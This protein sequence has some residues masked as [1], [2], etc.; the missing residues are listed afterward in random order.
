MTAFGTTHTLLRGLVVGMLVACGPSPGKP[1]SA[2]EMP[3]PKPRVSVTPWPSHAVSMAPNQKSLYEVIVKEFV[4]LGWPTVS[5]F[6]GMGPPLF[7][8][9]PPGGPCVTLV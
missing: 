9:I 6:T 1:S 5:A 7:T 3:P 2:A 4:R 8:S